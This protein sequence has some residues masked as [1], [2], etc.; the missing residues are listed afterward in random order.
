VRIQLGR[1]FAVALVLAV[2]AVGGTTASVGS[3]SRPA[4][5][6]IID[7][8]VVCQMPAEGFPDSI[9]FMTV[10]ASPR[11]LPQPGE[12][13][14]PTDT[15]PMMGAS[16]GPSAELRALIRTGADARER[17]GV[18]M[19]SRTN[20][21]PTKL[22]VHLSTRGLRGGLT[23]RTGNAY[24]CDVPSMI[25]LRVRAE[26][27]RPAGFSPDPRTAGASVTRGQIAT[28]YL[29][30]TTLRG[31]KPVAFASV[32]DTTGKA[33]IF[34]ARSRCTPATMPPSR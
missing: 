9:R 10:S 6:R 19:L 26:F 34:T 20:C 18:V 15:P 1:V 23:D 27:K 14:S 7:R 24:R 33:R 3:E 31:R 13:R 22:R 29:A 16:N 12:A 32:N 8:T 11:D 30:I 2:P 28:G 17:T 25:L 4:V 21:A 5:S